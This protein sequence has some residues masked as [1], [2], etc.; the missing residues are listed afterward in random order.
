[1]PVIAKIWNGTEPQ[2]QNVSSSSA[3]QNTQLPVDKSSS[4]N[5]EDSENKDSTTSFMSECK[6]D[7]SHAINMH[8]WRLLL[9]SVASP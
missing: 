2:W 7:S 4:Q 3:Y 9:E 8:A 6:L 5:K 1:M